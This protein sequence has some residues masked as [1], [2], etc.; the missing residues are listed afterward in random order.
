MMSETVIPKPENKEDF[1]VKGW[2]N[3]RGEDALIYYIPNNKSP[4]KP[5][6]KG[7]TVS[8]FEKAYDEITN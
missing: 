6:Q 8:K 5:Y 7:I 1:I 4:S 3:R 2:G